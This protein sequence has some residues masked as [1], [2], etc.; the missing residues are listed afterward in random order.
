MREQKT[1]VASEPFHIS[2][3]EDMTIEY[4][5]AFACPVLFI[6]KVTERRD[7]SVTKLNISLSEFLERYDKEFVKE[8]MRA[9]PK[10]FMEIIQGTATEEDYDLTM[11]QL[12]LIINELG[13]INKLNIKNI[14]EFLRLDP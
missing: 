9:L 10:L 3:K 11:V 1:Y 12:S 7:G 2:C 14:L 13:D 8:F 4:Y 6:R 5:T